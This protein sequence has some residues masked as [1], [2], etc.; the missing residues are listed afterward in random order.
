MN[1]ETTQKESIR[2]VSTAPEQPSIEG[3][4]LLA[5]IGSGGMGS[6]YKARQTGSDTIFAIKVLHPELAR[7]PVNVRRFEQEA[8][9]CGKLDNPHVVNVY[10]CGTT[11]DGRPYLVMDYICGS[12]LN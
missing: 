8:Q 12:G 9:A 10:S 7:D 3:F 4:E 1:P 2:L 5:L 6:V 11:A